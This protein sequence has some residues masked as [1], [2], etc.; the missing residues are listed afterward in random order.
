MDEKEKQ[1]ISRRDFVKLASAGAAAIAGTGVLSPLAAQAQGTAPVIPTKWDLE[2]DVVVIGSGAMGIPAAI[3]AADAGASVIVV[4][5]NYDIGGHAIVSGGNTPLGGGTSAQKKYKIEDS[6]DVL[7]RD[8]TDWSIVEVNGMPEY[9]YNDRGVQRALADNEAPTY[10]FLVANG[11]EF[12][13]QTPDNAGAHALGLSAKREN[14]T[15]WG[16]GQS[17]ESPAGAGGTNLMRPLEASARKKGVKFLLNY[18]MDTLFREKPDSGKV[19]G[20]Q[21]SYTPTIL[22]GTT[23]PLKSFRTDGNID[24]STKTVT[25]RAKKAVIIGTGGSTGNVNFR[26]MFD[27]RLTEEFPLAADEFSPQ[28]A[29]G[30]LAAMAIGASLWGTANQTFDRNGALRKRPI[31]GTRTNYIGWTK[32]SPLFP[33]V[34]AS[35][36]S[37]RNWQDAIIVNQVGKRFYNEMED[38]YPSGT[39]HGF[40]NPYVPGDWRNAARIKYTPMN[41]PDAALAINE[42]S[43][44]P[45]YAAG[46]Q[47]AIFDAEAVKREKWNLAPPATHPDYFFS[48]KTLAELAALL[49]KNPYQKVKMPAANLEETVK[50]YNQMVDLG[51]DP[52]FAKPSPRF[53]IETAPFYAAWATLTVHDTYAGLRINM[54]CQVMDMKGQVIPGLYCGGE[55]A[56][57]CSQHGLG[58][59]VTQGYIAG[60]E[61]TNE[62][63]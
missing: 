45:D 37:V 39:Y 9:R 26:R 27:P 43:T 32:N 33:K 20:I 8:L 18:H 48:A 40:L 1:G 3:R 7:F 25:V 47:W 2:A 51:V 62:R 31:I 11:V 61:A 50:R 46:P 6:P 60:K 41:Y 63:V 16:K 44:A 29:S 55:S 17:L 57:G 58:R 13:D 52:D 53:N 34:G 30:E 24:M 49:T 42:G 19:L 54:K 10:E 14:H 4:D 59:C 15:I 36:V 56:A 38:G 28:D 21:A 35:G 23:T 22:P 5:T 12:V